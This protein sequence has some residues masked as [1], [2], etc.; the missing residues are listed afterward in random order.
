MADDAHM[1]N[2]ALAQAE[3]A[4]DRGEFPVGCVIVH[5]ERI[6]VTGSRHGTSVQSDGMN[7]TDHAEM[8]ALRALDRGLT[9]PPREEM[10]LYSTMEPCLMCFAA[11]LLSRIGRIVYAFED[12]MG[13]GTGVE[14]G[15]LSPLYRDAH[16]SVTGGV[17]RGES[18]RLFKAFFSDPRNG[19]W[20]GSLLERYTLSQ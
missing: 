3:S 2:Q 20:R 13:G 14:L 8:I 18:L 1:M 5:R 11:I 16:V 10:I 19:Y 15:G 12:V 6:L 4:L 7:E 9:M 17:L